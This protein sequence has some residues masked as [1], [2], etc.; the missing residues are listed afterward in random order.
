M[1]RGV[2][3]WYRWKEDVGGWMLGVRWTD[4][5]VSRMNHLIDSLNIFIYSIL[6]RVCALLLSGT[7]SCLL[8]TFWLLQ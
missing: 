1:G 6:S 4:Q 2:N 8:L 5:R 7:L 3:G